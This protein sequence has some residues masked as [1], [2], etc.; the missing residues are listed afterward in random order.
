[1]AGLIVSVSGIRGIVGDT[2]TVEVAMRFARAFGEQ[3]GKGLVLVGTD[4]RPSGVMLK[5]AISAG[6]SASGCQTMDVGV[7]PTPTMGV[8]ITSLNAIGGIQITAS[9]NSAPYNGMKMFGGDGRVIPAS[10]GETIKQRFEKGSFNHTRWNE[11]PPAVQ[12]IDVIE[13]HLQKILSVIDVDKIRSSQL[14][15]FVDANGGAGGPIASRLLSLLGV[16]TVM[17]GEN[18]D[19][20]FTHEPEP[21]AS[22]LTQIGPK[23]KNAKVKAGFILDPDADR[24]AL[25]DEEGTFLGEE[26]TLALAAWARL[27]EKSGPMVINMSTSLASEQIALKF[28]QPCYRSA[29]GEANVVDLMIKHN[30]IIGGEGNGGVIDPRIGWVRDPFIG[31]ALLLSLMSRKKKSLGALAREIPTYHIHKDKITMDRSNLELWYERVV[32]AFVDGKTER[33]DGLRIS[34][35]GKWIHLR[36]S[37]TEPIVRVI[38]EAATKEEA[39][40]ISE[41]CK[42]LVI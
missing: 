35:P 13:H 26:L 41:Y 14:R 42:A 1:M 18:A 21:I 4:G 15:V 28:N 38:A 5:Q 8:A 30:A 25:F 12:S 36:P 20:N 10:F 40:Q 32:E 31:M 23:V 6:L 27:E 33:T 24:L 22:N 9:H 2:L 11:V 37:N 29:V 3:L 39:V 34:W 17:I 7:V 16:S 19:G